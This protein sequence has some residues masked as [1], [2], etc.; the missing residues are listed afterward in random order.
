MAKGSH[1]NRAKVELRKVTPKGSY[2]ITGKVKLRKQPHT[3][4]D[5]FFYL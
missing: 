3:Y 2:S 5:L 4:A 1:L